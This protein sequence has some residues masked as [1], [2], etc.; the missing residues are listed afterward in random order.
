MRAGARS[1]C[2]GLIVTWKFRDYLADKVAAM[3]N[4][5]AF[6]FEGRLK[7]RKRK[8]WWENAIDTPLY[9]PTFLVFGSVQRGSFGASGDSSFLGKAKKVLDRII[10]KAGR[11]F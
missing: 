2:L 3:Q 8:S 6:Y 7:L 5:Q 4:L 1:S 11:G 10:L 9:R